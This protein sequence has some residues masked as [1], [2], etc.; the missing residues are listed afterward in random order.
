M[1]IGVTYDSL[2]NQDIRGIEFAEESEPSGLAL[3]GSLGMNR[4]RTRLLKR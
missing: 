4:R 2:N 1:H 3:L